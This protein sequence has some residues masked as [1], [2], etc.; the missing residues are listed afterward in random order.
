MRAG[1][2]QQFLLDPSRFHRRTALPVTSPSEVIVR[3]LERRGHV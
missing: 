1:V 2:L 3:D